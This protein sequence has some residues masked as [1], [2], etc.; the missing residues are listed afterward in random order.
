[1][2]SEDD[3][4]RTQNAQRSKGIMLDSLVPTVVYDTYWR[5]A[6]ERQDIFFRRLEPIADPLTN[7][8]ILAT[9]KF[10][11]AYRASDRVSQYLIRR[12]IGGSFPDARDIFFRVI[13]FKLFNKIET[14]EML[15]SVVGEV[16]W[17]SFA[18]SRYA[19]ILQDAMDHQRSIYSAAYIMPTATGFEGPRKHETHLRL[20]QHMINENAAEKIRDARTMREAFVILHGFPMLGNFLAYQFVTDLNY[21][22][23]TQFSEMEFV[24][25]GPGALDGIKKCFSSLG[26]VSEGDVIRIMAERQETEFERLG[27]R[28]QNLWGRRLQLIDCQNL[29]CEVDKYARIAHPEFP[30]R[31][32]RTRI[33][34]L[35]ER[36]STPIE[37]QYPTKWNLRPRMRARASPAS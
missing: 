21:S 4:R 29:F 26:N 25:P 23:L 8:P 5:F 6:A 35:F 17:Q 11:N 12:V 16:R 15:E 7:D 10:T 32:G 3:E 30:G 9:Y 20:L 24:V 28:F 36:D 22:D 1:M 37:Y 18:L 2:R 34:Q 14:W 33:K 13:L 31:R 27:L 19:R